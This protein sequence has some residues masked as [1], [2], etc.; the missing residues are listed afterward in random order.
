[1]YDPSDTFDIKVIERFLKSHQIIPDISVWYKVIGQPNDTDRQ[2]PLTWANKNAMIIC[3][4]S[5][6]IFQLFN[7]KPHWKE[8]LREK[9]NL[10]ETVPL[11]ASPGAWPLTISWSSWILSASL[12][13]LWLRT[14]AELQQS[15]QR[16]KCFKNKAR[17]K[18]CSYW[19][20]SGEGNT[21]DKHREKKTLL[22][23]PHLTTSTE[24]CFIVRKIP[25]VPS[26]YHLLWRHDY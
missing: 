10:R 6:K 7:Y 14:E 16:F 13:G 24:S 20:I 1:M 12:K 9:S 8:L 4:D 26:L 5:I 25:N 19:G 18:L 22:S 17:A 15:R 11:N 23:C 3:D 21:I 2:A